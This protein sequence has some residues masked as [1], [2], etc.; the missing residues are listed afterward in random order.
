MKINIRQYRNLL[1]SNQSFVNH[2]GETEKIKD[3]VFMRRGYQ[4]NL[5]FFYNLNVRNGEELQLQRYIYNS[6]LTL[7]KRTQGKGIQEVN[8]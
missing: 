7:S 4:E 8:V 2:K 6:W 1:I 3:Q 5:D